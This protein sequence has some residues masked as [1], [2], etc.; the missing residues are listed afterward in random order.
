MAVSR[1][2]RRVLDVR[3]IEEE[4]SRGGVESAVGHLKRLQG[5]LAAARM[6]ERGG[7]RLVTSSA[8]TGELVDRIAGLE[9]T[10]TA[11]RQAAVLETKIA[12]AEQKV[13]LL[14]RELIARRVNRR[15]V[16]AL[17]ERARKGE[18]VA[19]GR[20]AQKEMDDWFLSRMR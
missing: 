5:S 8:A 6:R 15:Q 18:A 20:R 1:A 11:R 2:M 13:L 14:R 7:R 17:I 12:E 9:E 16:E 3:Q 19:A 4:Q 10:A